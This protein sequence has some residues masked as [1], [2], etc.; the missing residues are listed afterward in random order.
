MYLIWLH[1]PIPR[2]ALPRWRACQEILKDLL[3]SLGADPK[4]RDAA[5]VL[6][7][8]GT[9]HTAPV[10]ERSLLCGWFLPIIL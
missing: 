10:G 5:R 3:A 4:A 6:R 9:P 1:S 7:V 8:V 2:A